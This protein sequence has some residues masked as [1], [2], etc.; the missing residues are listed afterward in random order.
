MTVTLSHADRHAHRRGN[1]YLANGMLYVLAC[2]DGPPHRMALVS[3]EG[4]NRNRAPVE[5]AYE[6][7][8]SDAEFERMA[9]SAPAYVGRLEVSE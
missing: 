1:V 6:D 3:L 7:V 2:V 4:G 8:A 9:A 5:T